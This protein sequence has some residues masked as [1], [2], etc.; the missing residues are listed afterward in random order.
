LRATVNSSTWRS[1]FCAIRPYE[2]DEVVLSDHLT[3]RHWTLVYKGAPDR[4]E[5][6]LA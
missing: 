4:S 5:P 2:D 3:A 6:F 1:A